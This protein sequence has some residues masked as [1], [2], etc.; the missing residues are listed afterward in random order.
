[1]NDQELFATFIQDLLAGQTTLVS[2]PSFRLESSFGMLQLVDNKAGVIA[3]G[4]VGEDPVK[5]SVKR[6][7]NC[8]DELR[9]TLGQFSF[10]PDTKAL[11]SQLV[12][13]IQIA[14]P[15]GDQLY[16]SQAS[17]IWRSWRR[18]AVKAVKVLVEGQWQTVQDITC[19]SGVVFFIFDT[20]PGEVQT[21]GN[22]QLAWLGQ[23]T[24]E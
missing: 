22:T 21:T 19:S 14:I 2:N 18:G 1:M 13:F 23:P 20:G 5:V 10:F 12:P 9:Q 6:H 7:I 11:K 8:W 4:K 3:T 17:E 24:E 16:E 15:E